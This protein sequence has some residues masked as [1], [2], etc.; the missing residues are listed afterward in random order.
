MR[1]ATPPMYGQPSAM[2]GPPPANNY[3]AAPASNYGGYAPRGPPP[4]QAPPSM[5]AAPPATAPPPMMAPASSAPPGAFGAAPTSSYGG[6][7]LAAPVLAAIDETLQAD[8]RFIRTT[9]GAVPANA[10]LK[11]Q[12]GIQLGATIRPLA[13]PSGDGI[14]PVINFGTCGVV[15]C[16]RCRTYVNPFAEF[17]ENGRRWKCNLCGML[18]DVPSQ[19]FC[20]LE[21][22][23]KR[24]DWKSRP[25]LV[26][27]QCEFV[28]PAEYMVRPPQAPV[29]FFVIDVSYG[30]IASGMIK[31]LV[32]TIK[33]SLDKLQGASR[34]Q[35][36]FITYDSSV[37]FY[38]L[39]SSLK[40]PQMFVVSELDDVYLPI[41]DDL[42][43]NLTD[44][45]KVVDAFLD[46]LSHM[47]KGTRDVDTAFG[48]AINAAFKVVQNIGGKMLVFQSS[49]PSLGVGALKHRENPKLL[50]TE[51]E[52]SLLAFVDGEKQ[53]YSKTA[54]EFTRAQIAIDMHLFSPQYTDVATL[55]SLSKNTGGEFYYYP[56][57]NEQ[58]DA[59][60]FRSELSHNLTRQTA[61]EAV[62]RIRV[63]QGLKITKFYGNFFIRGADLLAVPN[64]SSDSVMAFEFV[65]DEPAVPI[66][67]VAYI[68][69][70]LLYTTSSGER[71]IRVHTVA[72]PVTTLAS[73]V[74][75]SVD[76]DTL[77]NLDAKRC[78]DGLTTTGVD[79]TRK[80]LQQH[81]IDILRNHR[82]AT[83]GGYGSKPGQQS[84]LPTSLQLLPLYTMALQ[85]NAT[86]R[87]GADTTSDV[88]S[89]YMQQLLN[90]SVDRSKVFLYPRMF[91]LHTMPDNAGLPLKNGEEEVEGEMYE[92]EDQIR[93]PPLVNLS[94]ENLTSN[95]AFLLEDGV[96]MMLWL[97]K[98]VSSAFLNSL[99]GVSGLEGINLALLT[100]EPLE[101]SLS[102]RLC[103]IVNAI[104]DPS[105]K[106]VYQKL[107]IVRQGDTSNFLESLFHKYLI[108]DRA[109]FS[110][111]SMT[112]AEYLNLVNK[113]SLGVSS[114][115]TGG[116]G[117]GP[118]G[119]TPGPSSYSAP[120]VGSYYPTAR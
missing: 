77:C 55:S 66:G 81:C 35:V 92:G 119:S 112:Y 49:L 61:W 17:V 57:F 96:V 100:L 90:M 5:M 54:A 1:S 102:K 47:F 33:S 83:S 13:E 32:D 3:G 43:V 31:V 79:E 16:K 27:G 2:G 29:Y 37:H 70:A 20:H 52:K 115:P 62:M 11:A 87:G 44:S 72:I 39:K 40:A 14:T 28:A 25:E 26:K 69:G 73:D 95:G 101:N 86:F 4:M 71:R 9:V 41:P 15:R 74:F 7:Q 97:G 18:N 120:P 110:G 67:S 36:G 23:G 10:S 118:P 48:P 80:V 56:N 99:F 107:Y 45:R 94:A 22:D 85:K 65:H 64:C 60:K 63:S 109:N 8:T 98:E 116:G 105:Q 104:R 108:E 78:V 59:Q 111:G 113:T 106:S 93:M 75:N 38:S 88:R 46:G 19:Y 114:G 82:S 24:A 58:L 50:G 6:P 76:I 91:S 30:S 103:A 117:G 53:F 34:T 21:K 84:A 12:T 42:L 89:Y 68:Q 51:A